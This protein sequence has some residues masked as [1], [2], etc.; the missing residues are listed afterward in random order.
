MFLLA[1]ASM[2]WW[3][4]LCA[5]CACRALLKPSLGPAFYT[6]AAKRFPAPSGIPKLPFR[7]TS[8]GSSVGD[9]GGAPEVI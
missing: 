7:V 1:C 4:L 6:V 2:V 3:L 8:P 9:Q 5:A